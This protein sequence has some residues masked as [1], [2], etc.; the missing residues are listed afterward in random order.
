MFK[1]LGAP[2]EL[3][4]PYADTAAIPKNLVAFIWPKILFRYSPPMISEGAVQA[5]LARFVEPNHALIG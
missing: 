3:V 5:M 1:W 2:N 4:K